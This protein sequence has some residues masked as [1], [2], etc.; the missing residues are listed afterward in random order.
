MSEPPTPATDTPLTLQADFTK[1]LM[2]LFG[3]LYDSRACPYIGPIAPTDPPADVPVGELPDAAPFESSL[4]DF[5]LKLAFSSDVDNRQSILDGLAA[6]SATLQTNIAKPDA[7][8]KVVLG[9]RLPAR[10]PAGKN[11]EVER[12][13]ARQAAATKIHKIAT[14]RRAHQFD[15]RKASTKRTSEAMRK[16]EQ[17]LLRQIQEIRTAEL[18][19]RHEFAE[20]RKLQ[21][22]RRKKEMDARRAEEF[23]QVEEAR[24]VV[25]GVPYRS[26]AFQP[27]AAK[28]D[29]RQDKT[30]SWNAR[31]S[32]GERIREHNQ[33]S[34]KR[35][36]ELRSTKVPI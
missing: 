34:V 23:A 29:E 11:A 36:K 32:A 30:L 6:K 15:D 3:A 4:C 22:I 25:E 5:R 27:E 8:T 16:D 14:F 7:P 20:A 33:K 35:T 10:T 26:T 2:S 1:H 24:R 13:A 21:M 19:V 28:P 17:A 12:Q 31:K 18:A 9:E